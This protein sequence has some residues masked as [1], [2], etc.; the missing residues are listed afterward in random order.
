MNKCY[1]WPISLCSWSLRNDFEKINAVMKSY[2]FQ[3]VHLDL[4]P[5]CVEKSAEYVQKV[6]KQNWIISATMIG[7]PQEDYSTLET[8]R[9]TGGIVPDEYW[10]QNHQFFVNAVDVTKTLNVK[11]LTTH[12]GFIDHSC[13]ANYQKLLGRVK[14]MA[15][16]ASQKQVILLMETGQ[17]SAEDLAQFLCDLDHPA[18]GINFDPANMILYDKG[19]PCLSL[20]KLA[21]WVKHVHIKDA[22]FTRTPGLWGKEVA[23][24]KGQ[25]GTMAF[26]QKLK[27]IHYDGA[28]AVECEADSYIE[29]VSIAMENLIKF[30]G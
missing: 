1:I 3:H 7:F 28:V 26:L 24:G 27:E 9:Q 13:P 23:W 4:R 2:E 21:P 20:K 25:V 18:I 16:R 8:I 14:S 29:D 11:Y 10:E 6:L 15:D 30:Q 5:A 22:I 17:E 12:I 19:N